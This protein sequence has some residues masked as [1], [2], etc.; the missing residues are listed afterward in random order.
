MNGRIGLAL[1]GLLGSSAV[2]AEP[3]FAV[4]LGLKCV[5]CH[6]NPSGGGMRNAFGN[7]WGR[8]A[9]PARPIDLGVGEDWT[10]KVNRFI[11]LGTNLRASGSYTDTPHQQA[12]SA[13]SARAVQ[14][15]GADQTTNAGGEPKKVETIRNIGAKVGRNDPCPCGSGKKYKNCHMNKGG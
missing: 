11:G 4:Q 14:E 2:F 9:L 10:G 12:Q 1:L 6:V 5:A 13:L 15:D 8:T 3:Y 7:T